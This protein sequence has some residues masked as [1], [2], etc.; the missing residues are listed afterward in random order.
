[1]VCILV[2]CAAVV[3]VI[4][5]LGTV[6]SWSPHVLVC[7]FSPLFLTAVNNYIVSICPLHFPFPHDGYQAVMLSLL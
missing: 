7:T 1:M 3:C 4:F 6:T 2:K 5:A